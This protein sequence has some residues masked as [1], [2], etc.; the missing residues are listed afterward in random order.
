MNKI[1]LLF[2][3]SLSSF[4]AFA[5]TKVKLNEKVLLNDSSTTKYRLFPT[6]NLWTFIK[7][8]TSTGQ[9]WQVQFS[10]DEDTRFVTALNSDSLA[11]A[12]NAFNERFT[13]YS[14]QN[15]YTFILLD[16]VDGRTWQVQW[17]IEPSKRLLIQIK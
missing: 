13:L 8:N 6:T 11:T 5:Q 16:R 2:I 1:I 3:I 4:N 7:L 17:S 15:M 12:N 9:M 14:T 10:M